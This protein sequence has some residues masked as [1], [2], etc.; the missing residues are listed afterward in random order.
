MNNKNNKSS[1]QIGKLERKRQKI[2][3][4]DRPKSP[5]SEEKEADL[6]KDLLRKSEL[7]HKRKE[8][9]IEDQRSNREERTKYARYA[10][11]FMWVYVGIV[12]LIVIAVGITAAL[13]NEFFLQPIPLAILISTIPASMALFGWVLKGLFPTDK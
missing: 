5:E 4:S 7:E 11:H 10:F 8:E 2:P 6:Y 12:I 3:P 13:F 9:D 1:E